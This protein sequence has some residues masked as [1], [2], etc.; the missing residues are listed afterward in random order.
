MPVSDSAIP[1][2]TY[3][4]LGGVGASTIRHTFSV[5]ERSSWS[6]RTSG[7]LPVESSEVLSRTASS[8]SAL[9]AAPGILQPREVARPRLRVDL[10]E[11]A[12]G[13]RVGVE[14]PDPAR[15]VVEVAEDDRLG[16]T[17]LG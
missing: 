2:A 9:M 4:A 17:R 16:R 6:P 1:K 12:V 7:A 11:H 5:M 10:L 13:A 14:L 15:L 3:Q 8:S